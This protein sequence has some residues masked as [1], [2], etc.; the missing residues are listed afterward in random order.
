MLRPARTPLLLAAAVA[1]A[2]AALAPNSTQQPPYQPNWE[3]LMSRPLP[4]WYDD[5]KIGLFMHWGVYS[6]PSFGLSKWEKGTVGAIPGEWLPTDPIMIFLL[7][8]CPSVC[9]YRQP[10]GIGTDWSAG[11]RGRALSITAH[12]GQGFI[13]KNLLRNLRPPSLTQ[14]N[15]QPSSKARESNM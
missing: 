8:V 10:N 11:I 13:T 9:P 7:R 15:G 4:T 1:V 6:V 2:A 14:T 5:A 12:M 3:S